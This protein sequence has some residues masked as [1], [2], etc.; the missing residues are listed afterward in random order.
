MQPLKKKIGELKREIVQAKTALKFADLEQNLA[1]LDE[2]L[3][4]PEIWHNPD[5]AQAIALQDGVQEDIRGLVPA[6]ETDG[7]SGGE[8]VRVWQGRRRPGSQ[9]PLLIFLSAATGTKV[10]SANL[11]GISSHRLRLFFIFGNFIVALIIIS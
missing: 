4:Q 9:A 8:D 1:E 3:N 10:I 7:E 5:E 6:Q 2:R 11:C